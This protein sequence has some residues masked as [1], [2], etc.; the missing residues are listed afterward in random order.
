MQ[1]PDS[2]EASKMTE[3]VGADDVSMASVSGPRVVKK[4]SGPLKC[5]CGTRP[6]SAHPLGAIWCLLSMHVGARSRI[7]A[8]LANT[9]QTI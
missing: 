4:V 9:W 1:L 6:V 7:Q 2:P 3:S 8:H 5:V